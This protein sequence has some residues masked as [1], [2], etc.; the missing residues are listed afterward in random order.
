MRVLVAGGDG[1][2]GWPTALYL[3]SRG[4]DVSIAD[5]LSRR[6]W[7][8]ELGTNSLTEISE[9][10]S[11][12]AR[13]KEV[14][15][16][17]IEAFVGDLT[18][19][20]FVYE[21]IE[22]LRPDA[23]VQFA[24]Q[25]SAPYSMI[26]RSHAV[27]TQVNNVVGTMNLMFAIG[28]LVPDC[29]LIK[30]GT[31]GEYGTPNIDIEE[32]YLTVE[33]KGRTDTLPYPKQPGSFYHLSKVHDSHNIMFACRTWGLRA[34]DLNQGVVYNVDTEETASDPVLRNRFDYDG[35]FGTALNR[36]CAQ[37]ASGSGITVYGGGG[38]TRGFIDI[39]DTVRCVELA[40][41]HPAERGEFRVFNQ[42]TEQWSVLE[43]AQLVER[44][45]RSLD[46]QTELAYL[47]NPRVEKEEHYY[48]A[49]NTRLIDLG[50]KPHLLTEETVE[51]LLVMAL[52]NRAR[53]EPETFA[54]RVDWRKPD[55]R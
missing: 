49:A 20:R 42:F 44:V 50:L 19:E 26:D 35:I 14:S 39:R 41:N 54:P 34:T 6:E 33:Y 21:T 13:W 51:R 9:P 29:H 5:N 22:R 28:E 2:C 17:E 36:F 30:L 53:I 47:D 8:R 37:A 12:V 55:Y 38:Q 18:D 27:F 32:G 4:H 40:A 11:R 46:L 24:E 10:G 1:F 25:R 31:M 7:D 15:G 43:L 3:S 16:R 52:E 45:A 23:V 48:R